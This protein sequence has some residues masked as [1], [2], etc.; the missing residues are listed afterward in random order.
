M[1]I[2]SI[3]S[4]A[5]IA[6]RRSDSVTEAAR[7]MRM[8]H[9]GSLVVV[10]DDERGFRI[11]VGFLTDR[12]IT[13]SVT[14]LELDPSIITVNEVMVDSVICVSETAGI[15]ETV[16]LMRDKGVR[17]LPVVDETGALA[18]IVTA[19]DLIALF[20]GELSGLA[21]SAVRERHRERELRRSGG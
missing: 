5:A 7:L 6:I 4:R 8:H 18:G 16:S 15:A 9:V 13:V 12:D 1:T 21:E 10:D 20:A 17:R 19:D 11:P 14:A 3:C 2:A